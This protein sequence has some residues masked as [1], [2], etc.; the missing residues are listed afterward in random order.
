MLVVINSLLLNNY[1]LI[2]SFR[3]RSFV[4]PLRFILRSPLLLELLLLLL[5]LA[6]AAPRGELSGE[7][8]RDRIR[9]RFELLLL[10]LVSVFDCVFRVVVLLDRAWVVAP[11]RA[12]RD[13]VLT[14]RTE[15]PASS[16]VVPGPRGVSASAGKR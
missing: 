8:A 5:L 13:V 2:T 15:G 16:V 1:F 6:M 14:V 9:V 4:V 10:L 11:V 12:G 7:I 3:I